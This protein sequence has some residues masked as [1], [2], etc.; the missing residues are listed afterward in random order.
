QEQ[1]ELYYQPRFECDSGRLHGFEASPFWRHPERGLLGPE[2][3]LAIAEDSALALRLVEWMLD[4]ACT[5]A[6]AWRREHPGHRLFTVRL[7]ARQFHAPD[8]VGL[9]RN[10]L[11]RSG[12]P[13]FCLELEV[14]EAAIT[15]NLDAS[16]GIMKQL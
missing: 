4:D 16:T 10:A 8:L 3:F 11:Q 13:A 15:R 12:L 2:T 6:Q 14:S 1:L 7:S 9:V 5:Q